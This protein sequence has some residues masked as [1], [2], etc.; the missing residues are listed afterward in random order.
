MTDAKLILA[1]SSIG[2]IKRVSLRGDAPLYGR[3]SLTLEVASLEPQALVEWFPSKTPEEVM[4]IYGIFGGT[5]A[6]LEHVDESPSAMENVHRVMP[7]KGG[8]LYDEPE[9]LIMQEVRS[10]GAYMDIMGA[11]SAGRQTISE[12][13]DH[14]RIPRENLPKYIASLITMRLVI[15]EV[16]RP[17][18]KVS[19]IL[20]DPF[21]QFWFR[22]VWANRNLLEAGL[23]HVVWDEVE[24][25]LGAHLGRVFEGVAMGYITR[26]IHEGRLKLSPN[27]VGRWVDRDIEIDIVATAKQ[28]ELAYA[29][30]VKWRPLTLREAQS[31]LG[32][33]ENKALSIRAKTKVYGLIAKSVEHKERLQDAGYQV[34]TLEEIFS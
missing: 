6:H 28:E 33:L 19:H 22:F 24:R 23:N 26:L 17:R 7:S 10:P 13:A 3:K 16:T 5:P 9:F 20:A 30:E 34:Y 4:A 1:G 27:Y 18:G 2:M 31:V 32:N 11:I 12:I 8:A 29:F 21:L 14:T 15:R 25:E